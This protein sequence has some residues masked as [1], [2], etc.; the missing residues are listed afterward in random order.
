MEDAVSFGNR[1]ITSSKP[2]DSKIPVVIKCFKIKKLSS[3]EYDDYINSISNGNEVNVPSE[4][5]D[6]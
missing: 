5:E 1:G 6:N 2:P 3:N 4:K